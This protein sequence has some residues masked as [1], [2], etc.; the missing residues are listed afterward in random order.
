MSAS[1]QEPHAHP[2]YR[3]IYYALLVL[4]AVSA[5][6]PILALRIEDRFLLVSVVL[7]TAFGV[8]VIKAGMVAAWFMHLNVESRHLL[9][10]LLVCLLL[11]V[12]LF[13]G[14][15]PDVLTSEGQNRE[16]DPDPAYL[17]PKPASHAPDPQP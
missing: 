16:D 4:L 6:G 10:L 5:W 7:A 15:A 3:K 12:L 14:V 13:A 11:L 8:A 2:D 17:Y 9:R 1:D